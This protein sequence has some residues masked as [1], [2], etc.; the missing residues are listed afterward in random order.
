MS[1]DYSQRLAGRVMWMGFSFIYHL[2]TYNASAWCAVRTICMFTTNI[3]LNCCPQI[4]QQLDTPTRLGIRSQ[5]LA[6]PNEYSLGHRGLSAASG[7]KLAFTR[8]H[9]TL[10][11]A[12]DTTALYKIPFLFSFLFLF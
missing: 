8:R 1:R 6:L 10:L 4:V 12:T 3:R 9:H 11:T 5:D 7:R 2:R